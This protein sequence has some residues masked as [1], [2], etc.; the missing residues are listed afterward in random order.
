VRRARDFEA[1]AAAARADG[2]EDGWAEGCFEAAHQWRLADRP[3][4][5]LALYEQVASDSADVLDVGMAQ[6]SAAEVLLG[7]GHEQEGR[8][9][10]ADLLRRRPTPVVTPGSALGQ[11]LVQ[12]LAEPVARWRKPGEGL[13]G[14]REQQSG[15][16]PSAGARWSCDG[17]YQV[18]WYA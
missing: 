7:T 18:Q 13:R 6:V 1:S 3:D 16:R 2:D 5:A 9:R 14:T 11:G 15:P 17:G 4:R 8:Q 10:L 12:P